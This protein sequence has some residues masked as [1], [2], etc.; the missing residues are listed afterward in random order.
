MSGGLVWTDEY[1]PRPSD[2]VYYEGEVEIFPS[3]CL[4]GVWGFRASLVRGMPNERCRSSW[5]KGLELFPNWPGFLPERREA[6]WREFLD[7][8]TKRTANV[9]EDLDERWR[10]QQ[11]SPASPETSESRPAA[12]SVPFS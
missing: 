8:E 2:G 11:S 6:K 1:P 4:R 9:F 3:Y 5:E 12:S 7:R 10:R